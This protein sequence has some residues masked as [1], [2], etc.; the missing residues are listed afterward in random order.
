MFNYVMRHTSP[1]PQRILQP[2]KGNKHSEVH[3]LK[4]KQGSWSW[5]QQVTARA[6]EDYIREEIALLGVGR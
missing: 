3:I 6:R 2:G 1:L 5:R 4:D